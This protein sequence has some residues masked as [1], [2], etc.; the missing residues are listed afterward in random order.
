MV[1]LADAVNGV[2]VRQDLF[3]GWD[4]TKG[5]TALGGQGISSATVFLGSTAGGVEYA[6]ILEIGVKYELNISHSAAPDTVEIRESGSLITSSEG[7]TWFTATATDFQIYNTSASSTTAMGTLELR[8]YDLDT[9]AALG[10]STGTATEYKTYVDTSKMAT[11]TG[12]IKEINFNLDL[13]SA[14][15]NGVIKVGC[16][17]YIPGTNIFY[18]RNFVEIDVT[19]DGTGQKT[20]SEANGDFTA[21]GCM[22]GDY[23]FAYVS[24]LIKLALIEPSGKSHAVADGDEIGGFIVS[25][26]G[27]VDG[28]VVSSADDYT[29]VDTSSCLSASGNITAVSVYVD[30]NGGEFIFGT[31]SLSGTTFTPRN[32]VTVDT[33]GDGVGQLNYSSA[34]GD[35]TAFAAEKGDCIFFYSK[36]SGGCTVPATSTPAAKSMAFNSGYH[37]ED[38]SFSVTLNSTRAYEIQVT[39]VAPVVESFTVTES[40]ASS[41]QLNANGFR[42][43]AKKINGQNLADVKKINGVEV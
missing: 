30:A 28:N 20:Y 38:S 16:G 2:A 22:R 4:F 10:T 37:V 6:G 39:G 42:H 36:I 8:K 21:F 32:W 13:N 41:I 12:K 18:P 7:V 15:N 17:N 33:T 3:R 11:G 5:W 26:L 34:G 24:N 43:E 19:G 1:L 27:T 40:T 14:Y 23:L 9:G 31:G 25:G 35:F 29:Y